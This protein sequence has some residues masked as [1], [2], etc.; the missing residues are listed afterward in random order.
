[1][2]LAEFG[3]VERLSDWEYFNYHISDPQVL[4]TS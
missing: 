4:F 1:M 3:G 2:I